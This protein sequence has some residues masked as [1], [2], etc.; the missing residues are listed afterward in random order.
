[1][2]VSKPLQPR[3]AWAH[4]LDW[5]EKTIGDQ[6]GRLDDDI[7]GWT[8]SLS[9]HLIA[10]IIVALLFIPLPFSQDEISLVIPFDEEASI[11]EAA[12]FDYDENV[13]AN[14]GASTTQGSES[15]WSVAPITANESIVPSLDILPESDIG[16]VTIV[17][18][19][20]DATGEHFNESLTVQGATGVGTTG[21]MGAIDRITHEILL[22]LEQRK[23]LVVW[24]FDE[25][26]SL[27]Q[28]R[29]LVRQRFDRVY[30]ELGGNCL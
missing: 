11:V 21:A 3:T 15:T 9:F 6:R 14:I 17:E 23:V 27:Q 12:E 8:I 4:W 30:T 1:M 2:A 28:Q 5:W 22:N 25:S 16:T 26:G 7:V 29:D 18:E 13:V 24:L 20:Q 10:L 19:M